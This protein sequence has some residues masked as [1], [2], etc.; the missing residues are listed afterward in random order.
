MKAFPLVVTALPTHPHGHLEAVL[1]Q[2]LP[3]I[4]RTVLRPPIR[5]VNA[6]FRRLPERDGHLQRPDREVAFHAIA[7]YLASLASEALKQSEYRT[8]RAAAI[9]V[10]SG[11]ILP[12]EAP[13][14]IM[15]IRFLIIIPNLVG[16][17]SDDTRGNA[18]R[19]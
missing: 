16:C 7:G 6:A 5:M 10:D 11:I 19:W 15:K 1:A 8:T 12:R 3:I 9:M 17:Q 14:L 4:V 13:T 2:Q 18:R